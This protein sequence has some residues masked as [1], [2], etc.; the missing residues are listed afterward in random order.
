MKRELDRRACLIHEIPAEVLWGFWLHCPFSGKRRGP[1][2]SS[3]EDLSNVGKWASASLP[4]GSSA[5]L[6]AGYWVLK[7][8][9]KSKIDAIYFVNIL[10]WSFS[11]RDDEKRRKRV[12]KHPDLISHKLHEQVRPHDF[13]TRPWILHKHVVR[14]SLCHALDRK[15]SD[16]QAIS[17]KSQRIRDGNRKDLKSYES[18]IRL[19]VSASRG[20]D[21]ERFAANQPGLFSA[22]NSH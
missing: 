14:P 8:N 2:P 9:M 17:R 16:T 18:Y 10:Y 12:R 6:S 11:S 20:S 5:D 7:V 21:C 3:E 22:G 19:V 1:P 13:T 4:P 15:S